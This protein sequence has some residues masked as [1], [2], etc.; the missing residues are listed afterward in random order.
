FDDLTH[1]RRGA[2]EVE[3]DPG[4]RMRRLEVLADRAERVGERRCGEDRQVLGARARR[5]EQREAEQ[6]PAPEGGAPEPSAISHW[7]RLPSGLGISK[8]R[9]EAAVHLPGPESQ[10]IKCPDFRLFPVG[11]RRTTMSRWP[12]C[13]Q[14]GGLRERRHSR[15][16]PATA[17]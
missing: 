3:L 12:P 15:A 8:P 4:A 13:A 5:R 17:G 6:D 1:Q 14:G 11:E 2:G 10:S 16:A 7:T 9:S